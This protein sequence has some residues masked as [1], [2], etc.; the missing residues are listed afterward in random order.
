M[1]LAILLLVIAGLMV[2]G[3]ML[4]IGNIGKPRLAVTHGTAI[5]VFVSNSCYAAILVTAA[6]RLMH[7]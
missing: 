4:V 1:T 2:A 5:G 3:T 7:A 6:L